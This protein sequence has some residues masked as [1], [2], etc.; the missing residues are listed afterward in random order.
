MKRTTWR[1]A[2]IAAALVA[3]PTATA[4]GYETPA[5]KNAL[6]INVVSSPAQ[7]VS[8][9][10]ARIEIAVP[11]KTP[12]GDVDVT[13]NGNDVTAA[14]G[15]D[16]EGNHQL[17]GVVTGLPL[18]Q[19]TIVASSHKNSKGNK[20]YDELKLTNNPIQ[21]PIFSGP[22]QQVFVCAT[23]GNAAGM[24]LPPIPQSP[25]C[26]TPTV[27]SF[28][29]R[30]LTGAFLPYDPASPPPASSIELTTTMDGKTVPMILRW[31]RGVINRFMYSILMLSPGSQ[32][33]T[34]DLSAWNR[35]AL[36]SFSG[37]VAIG[38]TQGAAS[39]GD[40]RYLA[41]L[42][43]GYA[44]LYSSGTRTN[45]HYNLQLGGETAIMLKDR[46]VSAYAEPEYTIAVGGSGGA[47]QQYVYGQ[48]HP[49]L[50]DGGVPQYSY[51]DMV[52]Q[53]I[54]VGDC[55][56]L[57]R[58]LDSKVLAS[59][60][61][62]WRTWVNRT[63]IEGLN[64][65]SVLPNPY[66]AVMPYMPTPGST[67]C[68]N[69][70]RG[71]SPLALNPNFG[72][73]PG[74]NPAVHGPVEWTHWGDLV[75]IYGTDETGFA[76]SPWDNVGV[77]YGLKAL[78]TG[79]ITPEQFLD[80]NANV[81]SWK[82]S[83]DMVQE[84]C[85]FIAALC[86][87]Q[88]P[89]VWSARNMSLSADG[90]ATPAARRTGD[91][92]AQYAAYRSGMVFRGK[93]DIP[94]IDWRHYLEPFLDMHNSHQ[95]FASRQRM[96]NYDGNARN[97]LIWFTAV[98]APGAPGAR[99]DQTPQALLVLD[100]W[101]KNIEAHPEFSV[102]RNKPA[103][104]VDSCFDQNGQLIAGGDDVWDGILDSGPKGACAQQ[105]PPFGTS[106]TVAG[107]PIQGGVFK[108]ALQPVESALAR[109]LYGTWT[110]SAS[111]LTRLKAIFPTGVCDYSKPDAGMPPEFYGGLTKP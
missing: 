109:G 8:G 97:Q 101:L 27:T 22:H 77:Q 26:E 83:K 78:Q 108:C 93:L 82:A 17:E 60:L 63:L 20:Y 34:P 51:P 61:S 6:T 29:Y 86:A 47:I 9:D 80:L 21:G 38:H 10:D 3:V 30:N 12:L 37:G 16:P 96:L 79:S 92:K 73:A 18:G 91:Q 23:P 48:N 56:L 67:E 13:L 69:G 57:E 81:G 70:W 72:T 2:V 25:T 4:A 90:G 110:P 105:F 44:V 84:G 111:E 41:G 19:S 50:I 94:V 106:R 14:F 66:A 36:F 103:D 31:E 11:D 68:I 49:G 33:A 39:S 42:R 88:L 64:S 71:L 24:G 75:N 59:P 89:D 45:T 100:R 102:G 65:S 99:F 62:T 87:T 85:P 76:R 40:M 58:W 28:V 107:G 43:M 46:F 74:Y 98:P 55:E 95:S 5:K 35:K 32:T 15:P 7:Y 52:T 54:H 53:T 104:A 1:L